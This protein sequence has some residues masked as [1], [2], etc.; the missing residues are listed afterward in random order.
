MADGTDGKEGAGT[1]QPPADAGEKESR[2]WGMLCHLSALAGVVIPGVGVV[3]GPLVVWM[4]KR[5]EFPFVDDQGKEAVN[6]QLPFAIAFVIL[7]SPRFLFSYLIFSILGLTLFSLIL[8]LTSL[9]AF[10]LGVVDLVLIITASMKANE[11]VA[12][13]YPFSL[14]LIK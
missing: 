9:A 4:L 5:E 11:G 2:M 10:A 12:Y 7:F 14:H 13:R 8:W 3:V 6:F 1:P